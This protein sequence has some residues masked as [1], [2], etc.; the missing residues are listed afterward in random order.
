MD[1]RM[2]RV[3]L[4]VSLF[5]AI[6]VGTGCGGLGGGV[7]SNTSPLVCQPASTTAMQSTVFAPSCGA[8]GCHGAQVP[9][10]GLDLVS[11]NLE[12]RIINAGANGCGDKVLVVA[13]D[14]ARS[15]LLQKLTDVT[16]PCGDRMPLGST[17]MSTA[18]IDCLT[19]WVANLKAPPTGPDAAAPDGGG[20]TADS[21]TKIDTAMEAAR[22][23]PSGQTSRGSQCVATATS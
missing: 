23:C 2:T 7:E 5:G 14:P 16:P 6:L 9:A 4:I 8:A 10:L 19:Q 18:Q 13:G 21:G 12:D 17:H 22:T 11:P 3:S 20:M 1:K 15:Y